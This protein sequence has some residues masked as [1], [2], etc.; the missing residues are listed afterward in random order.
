[1]NGTGEVRGLAR[2]YS[3]MATRGRRLGIGPTT[4]AELTRPAP[5]PTQGTMDVALRVSN[6]YAMGFF[7]PSA[8]LTFG[9]SPAAFG[10]PGG[11]GS[12]GFADPEAAVSYAY[13]MNRLGF[14]FPVDPRERAI[15]EA[16]YR[17]IDDRP[18]H[19]GHP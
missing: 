12:L 18:P 1:V 10:T 5:A 15:R 7:K 2:I 19:R 17:V 4:F 16:L 9:R 6:A 11:G 8:T 13:A 14:H 3:E